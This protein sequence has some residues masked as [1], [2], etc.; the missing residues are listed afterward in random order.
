M[1]DRMP[2]RLK[3]ASAE[4][5]LTRNT[6]IRARFMATTWMYL[7]R[8][9]LAMSV[10][11]PKFSRIVG[12]NYETRGEGELGTDNLVSDSGAEGVDDVDARE[13]VAEVLRVSVEKLPCRKCT[14]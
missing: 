13:D 4:R 9:A 8:G 11:T 14:Q 10:E 1:M 6:G 2:T 5:S 7:V 12:K 3:W